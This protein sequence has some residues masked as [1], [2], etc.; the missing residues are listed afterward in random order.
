MTLCLSKI[1]ND[2]KTIKTCFHNDG[3]SVI[4]V[5]AINRTFIYKNLNINTLR[6]EIKELRYNKTTRLHRFRF[7]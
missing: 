2:I 1:L 7:N 3:V 4:K 5:K 6:S